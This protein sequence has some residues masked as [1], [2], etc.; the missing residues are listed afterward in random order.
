MS[1]GIVYSFEWMFLMIKPHH[2]QYYILAERQ[3]AR[4][5]VRMLTVLDVVDKIV[6]RSINWKSHHHYYQKLLTALGFEG[7]SERIMP[8]PLHTDIQHREDD[9]MIFDDGKHI[10]DRKFKG[11]EESKAGAKIGVRPGNFACTLPFILFLILT[12]P[13]N[14]LTLVPQKDGNY[15]I[16]NDNGTIA[17]DVS[18][19][20]I[21][22]NKKK[23]HS[24][25]WDSVRRLLDNSIKYRRNGGNFR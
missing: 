24:W 18:T 22:H 1:W 3:R 9:S 6:G 16:I 21:I 4:C 20:T 19:T 5:P 11:G 2:K 15:T 23:Y 14:A 17:R 7:S 13:S 12:V 8:F 10:W 25:Y